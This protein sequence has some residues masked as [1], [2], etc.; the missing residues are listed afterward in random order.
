MIFR[1]SGVYGIRH[2]ATGRIYV[3]SSKDTR[4]RLCQHLNTLLS[5][6]HHS[7]YLQNAWRK[8]GQAAFTA[9]L[10]ENDV[11]IRKLVETEQAWI[12]LLDSY[13][14]GFNARPKA[15]SM[16]GVKWSEAQNEA[17]RQSNLKA[18]S[19]ESLR[20]KLSARFK[21][22]YRAIWTADSHKKAS[23]TLKQ[24]HAEN[25]AWRE[26]IRGWLR[27]PEN[28]AKRVSGLKAALKRPEVY[29][30]RVRQLN[31][32][33]RQPATNAAIREAYFEKFHREALGF[34][35][36]EEMDLACLRLYAD[37]KSCR[38]IGR[39]FHIDH[40]GI[41]SRLRRFG[42]HPKRTRNPFGTGG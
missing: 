24:R 11:P 1:C 23:Q 40:H 9:V 17:R 30:A 16:R 18:W 12:D 7:P 5:G 21:G 4:A 26:K 34:S 20:Q 22:R 31:E 36:P 32:A 14:K 6:R 27:R 37:G 39:L 25:P 33:R 13:E 8:Y 10:L 15:E 35:N 19:N 3:G 29:S 38:E 42:V 2:E 28:E 41:S